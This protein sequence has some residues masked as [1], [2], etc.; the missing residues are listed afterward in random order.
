MI[1]RILAFSA[2]AMLT[3]KVANATTYFDTLAP[4]ATFSGNADGPAGDGVNLMAASFS[5]PGTPNFN[6]VTLALTADSPSDGG[7]T[8]VYLVPDDG[9]G[10]PDVAGSPLLNGAGASF[11]DAVLLGTILDSSLDVSGTGPSLVKLTVTPAEVASVTSHTSDDEYWIGLV[12]S[13]SSSIEWDLSNPDDAPGLVDQADFNNQLGTFS[14]PGGADDRR[15]EC[16]GAGTYDT[17]HSRRWLG[18]NWLRAPS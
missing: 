18:W 2:L 13:G 6:S 1:S 16:V 10:A 17:C 8:M 12:A 15:R 3:A 5:D 9:S 14:D 4:S 11:V 7:S